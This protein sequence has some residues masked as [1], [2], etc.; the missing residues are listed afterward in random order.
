MWTPRRLLRR[1]LAGLVGDQSARIELLRASGPKKEDE[2]LARR[3][4]TGDFSVLNN[5][6]GLFGELR[7]GHYRLYTVRQGFDEDLTLDFYLRNGILQPPPV[8]LQLPA[9][10]MR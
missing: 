1:G 7:N 10:T 9:T 8:E 3:W 4:D 5:L 2:V 6:T